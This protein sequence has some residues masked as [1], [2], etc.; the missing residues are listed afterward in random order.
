MKHTP[1][2]WYMDY[3]TH[4]EEGPIY[5]AELNGN[6]KTSDG[7]IVCHGAYHEPNARL[8]VAAPDLLEALEA[9]Q[10]CQYNDPDN[11][12]IEFCPNC[13]NDIKHGHHPTCIIGKAIK[14][15]R[16]G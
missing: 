16:T 4:D 5:P 3:D 9:A 13:R 2:P 1:G 8:I 6:I 15:A 14:K 11:G 12:M 7:E 10:W